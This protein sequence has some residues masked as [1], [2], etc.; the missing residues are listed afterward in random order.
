M[1]IGTSG[2][3]AHLLHPEHVFDSVPLGALITGVRRGEQDYST[4]EPIRL[5]WSALPLNFKLSSPTMRNR[6][7]LIFRYRMEGLQP[8]WVESPDGLATFSALPPGQYTFLAMTQNPGLSAYSNVVQ[9]QIT[10]LP[11]W[12]RKRWFFALCALALFLLVVAADRFRA[13]RLLETR[14][15]LEKLVRERTLELEASR[16]LLRIQATHDGLTGMLNRVGILRALEAEMDRARRECTCLVVALIDLDHFKHINDAFGHLAGDEALRWF[17]AAVESAKRSY[18]HA[19]RYGGEEF[20]LVLPEIPP[21]AVE[22]RLATLH[23]SISNLQVHIE[24]PENQFAFTCSIGA[25]LFN[26]FTGSASV[27]ALLVTADRALYAAKAGGRNRCC[28]RAVSEAASGP[29]LGSL[30]ED[31]DRCSIRR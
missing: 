23:A 27:G 17:A 1:W 24:R 14:K 31:E 13:R 11:P 10:I 3:M 4:A 18:D 29:N 25:T 5:P 8:D 6:S 9:V 30:V 19:G 21:D 20:L 2:G 26:P 16:E 15:H 28:F 7:E 12:W 22:Q